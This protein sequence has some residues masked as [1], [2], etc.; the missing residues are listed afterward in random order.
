MKA[1]RQFSLLPK[2][3]RPLVLGACFLFGLLA[4]PPTATAVKIVTYNVLNY[5]GQ[6]GD[7]CDREREENLQYVLES[8]DADI[9][10]AQEISGATGYGNF[11]T[12]V[13]DIALPGAYTSAPFTNGYDSD[14]ALYYKA[15]A[16][17]FEYHTAI[18]TDLRDWSYYRVRMAGSSS[19]DESSKL[20]IFISHLKAGRTTTDKNRRETEADDYRTWAEANLPDGAHVICCGDFNL[21]GSSEAA[22]TRFTEYRY[23]NRGRLTDPA[24]RVG[25]WEYNSNYSDVH[26]QA[27]QT[28]TSCSA[29][30]P[31]CTF[32]GGGMDDRF[33]F[34]LTS[35]NLVDGTGMDYVPGTYKAF[36]ND[37]NHYDDAIN[38]SPTIPE[39]AEF[40]GIADAL[41][42]ASDHLPVVM[43]ID[44]T[45]P[46]INSPSPVNFGTAIVD[47]VAE[48]II[49][50]ENTASAPAETLEYHFVFPANFSGPAGTFYAEAGEGPNYHTLEMSS[51][52]PGNK[53]GT[54]EI[55]NNTPSTPIETTTLYGVVKSHAVP[56]VVDEE[57]PV[58]SAGLD[59]GT[60]GP[61][62][63]D[64]Q[65]GTIYNVGCGSHQAMLEIWD[66]TI[67]GDD[68]AR[69]DIIACDVD[70]TPCSPDCFACEACGTPVDYTIHFDDTGATS[71]DYTAGITF[72]TRDESDL[73]GA[74]SLP[75]V[76]FDLTASVSIAYPKGDLDRSG[77]VDMP[78]VP[79]FVTLLLDPAA[80]TPDD[81]DLADMN[82]DTFNR[83]DDI[84]LFVNAL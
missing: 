63:F 6:V 67:T 29:A 47:G 33:D 44:G 45:P 70:T 21:T 10:C 52:T 5:R 69:F 50:I 81:R 13:L 46:Q 75:S 41:T 22:W 23:P 24:G 34:L 30:I 31:S 83:G 9:V 42:C 55:H 66:Y 20:H 78:D 84:Q 62:E 3:I 51:S 73:P 2:R 36:G 11:K 16:I 43:E 48:G 76:T 49:A 57:P 72:S 80:A 60:H 12:R 58:I 15:S 40:P 17:T 35:L 68:A 38:D 8:I 59:F 82:S 27:P 56:S 79:L 7:D 19:G 39:E 32:L 4:M 18:P 64:D 53:M 54:L 28:S 1:I 26:T 65:T 37:G 61:G 74:T 14:N 71:G 77:V 25:E